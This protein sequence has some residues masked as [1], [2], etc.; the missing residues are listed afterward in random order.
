MH[1][2]DIYP[3]RNPTATFKPIDEADA[4]SSITQS[5]QHRCRGS[6]GLHEQPAPKSWNATA[7]TATATG[8][9]TRTFQPKNAVN[10]RTIFFQSTPQPLQMRYPAPREVS[11]TTLLHPAAAT[12][13]AP[14]PCT[15]PTRP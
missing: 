12:D 13:A 10:V 14:R 5:L 6:I 3:T 9:R 7:A 2:K 4:G 15:Q 8:I 11:T 1:N